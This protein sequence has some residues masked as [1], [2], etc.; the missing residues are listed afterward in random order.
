MRIINIIAEFHGG[1]SV[2]SGARLEF[3]N[4]KSRN[5]HG[6]LLIS[7]IMGNN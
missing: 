5:L 7:F 1:S 3:M 4:A 2:K 6:K